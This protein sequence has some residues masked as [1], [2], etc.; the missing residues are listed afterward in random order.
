MKLKSILSIVVVA[1]ASAGLSSSAL[2]QPRPAPPI[3]VRPAPPLGVRPAPPIGEDRH[4]HHDAVVA[5]EET[6]A[7]LRDRLQREHDA[8]YLR[9]Q[10][11]RRDHAAWEAGREQRALDARNQLLATWGPLTDRADARAEFTTHADRMAQLNRIL[12]VALDK[13]D[14][15]LAAHCRNVIQREIARDARIMAAIRVGAR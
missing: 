6:E 7:Q 14:S 13:G 15:A 9:R 11:A 1:T 4:E 8:E 5:H 10:A 3:G 12:D 2:A